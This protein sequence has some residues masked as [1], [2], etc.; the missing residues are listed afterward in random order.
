M[1]VKILVPFGPF[2]RRFHAISTRS[3]FVKFRQRVPLIRDTLVLGRTVS[4]KSPPRA[5]SSPFASRIDPVRDPPFRV[6]ALLRKLKY[7]YGSMF[8]Q[9]V[10]R[11][12][13]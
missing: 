11:R 1:I 10:G 13:L 5:T 2:P 12:H 6:A 9:K 8:V 4:S 3:Q 7:K